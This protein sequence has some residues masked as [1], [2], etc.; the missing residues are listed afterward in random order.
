MI[1]MNLTSLLKKELIL[2][3]HIEINKKSL[4]ER[5]SHLFSNNMNHTTE[6][7]DAFI[8][9]ESL[10]STALGYG[11]AIPHIRTKL[12]SQPQLA[13]IQLKTPINFD[14]DDKRPV[15]IIFAI[16]VPE[17]DINNHLNIL[18]EC[19]GLLTQKKFREKIRQAKTS[20]NIMTIINQMITPLEKV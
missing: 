19:S 16:I 1:Q 4:F 13:I 7:L 3:Q 17:E 20:S 14:A 18:A 8:S 6:L 11:V 9:R 10:G 2:C 15:D 12:L 5:L